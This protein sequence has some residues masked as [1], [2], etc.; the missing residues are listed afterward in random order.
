MSEDERWARLIM[1]L[2]QAGMTDLRVLEALERVPRD[3]FVEPS[4]LGDAYD[5]RAL[6]IGCG[7]TI[8][9]PLVV[10]LMTQALEVG[11]RMKVLE[12]GTGSGYQAAVLSRLCRRV[13]SIE[14]HRDLWLT[15]QRRFAALGIHNVTTQLG[16]GWKGWPEQAPFDRIIVT[17]AA[18]EIPDALK[19]QLVVGGIMVIPVGAEYETQE[20]LQVR[21]TEKGLDVRPMFPVRFVPMLHGVPPAAR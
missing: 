10:G 19:D 3:A 12:I 14:R 13:Y 7:Q 16:D 17:A 11:E 6:P 15:A 1:D 8:S 18:S 9:Q 4:L 2:R 5:N 21:K 20:L